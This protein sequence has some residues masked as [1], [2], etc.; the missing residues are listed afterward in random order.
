MPVSRGPV[1]AQSV[2]GSAALATARARDN[3]RAR[4]PT[5]ATPD[6]GSY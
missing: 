3:Q 2:I 5:G 6:S 1:L 4:R